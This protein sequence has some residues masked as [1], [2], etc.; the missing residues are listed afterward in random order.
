M[1]LTENRFSRNEMWYAADNHNLYV[2]K[3]FLD[4]NFNQAL[5]GKI[6]IFHEIAPN[7]TY[8]QKS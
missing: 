1:Y 4:L 3:E 6:L 7:F 2:S 8:S 5:I